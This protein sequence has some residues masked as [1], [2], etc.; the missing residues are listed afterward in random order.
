MPR[1]I[2]FQES[3][4]GQRI[5]VVSGKHRGRDGFLHNGMNETN[6]TIYVILKQ[7]ALYPEEAKQLYKTS[8]EYTGRRKNHVYWEQVLLKSP[9]VAPH[10]ETFLT[11]LLE[12]EFEPTA[13]MMAIIFHAWKEKHKARSEQERSRGYIRVHTELKHPDKRKHGNFK[14]DFEQAYNS[15]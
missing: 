2:K 14:E 4:K 15:I 11:K 13:E 5:S 12:A 1:V 3:D 8:I 6:D 9:K 10:F 7:T